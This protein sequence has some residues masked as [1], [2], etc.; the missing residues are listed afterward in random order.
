MKRDMI[1][2]LDSAWAI[3]VADVL[4]KLD[5]QTTG[6]SESE[7][8]RRLQTFGFNILP[9][10]RRFKLARILL[11][12]FKSP[13]III[14]ILAGTV[15]AI[16]AEWKDSIA[17]FAA[18][19]LNAALGFYQES[20]AE[21]ALS[22]LETYVK[23]QAIVVR[24][25]RQ[26]Q[27][28]AKDIVPG[29]IV[30]ISHGNRI[31]ADGRVIFVNDFE[32]DES[33]LTGE[34][35]SIEKTTDTVV[36]TAVLADRTNMVYMGT[37]VV[38]GF[39]DMLVTATGKSTELGII[40]TAVKF[41]GKDSTPLEKALTR[42]TY[43]IGIIVFALSLGLFLFGLSKGSTPY[44]MF[45]L[46][47]AVGVSAVPEGLP[48]ALTVILASGVQRLAR[49]KGV[50]RK[51]LAAET[52]GGT[53]VVMTDKTGTLT[54]AKMKL[55]RVVPYGSTDSESV[56]RLVVLHSDAIIEN[57]E[58]P[59]VMWRIVGRPIETAII[60]AGA[61][62]NI[63]Q[64]VVRMGTNLIERLPFT[65]T[66]KYSASFFAQHDTGT[67][68]FF[69]APEVILSFSNLNSDE[70]AKIM[71]MVDA[72]A[73]S[74]DRVLALSV[75][76]NASV[77]VNLNDLHDS[78]SAAFMGLIMFRDPVRST[79]RESIGRITRAGVRMMIVTGDHPG[80]ARTVGEELG[81][82]IAAHQVITGA[83]LDAMSDDDIKKRLPGLLVIARVSPEQKLR[84]AR[85][86]QQMGEVVAMTGD[87]VNDA[88]ALR[89]ADIGIAV[90]SGS[91]VAK[92][93][94][95]LVILDN[96]FE[97]IVAAIEEGR[98]ILQNIR[99][100]IAYLMSSV[101]DELV[102]ISG[103]LLL[104]VALPLS[105]LQILWVNLMIGALPAVALAF[106]SHKSDIG[107]KPLRINKN[108]F[109]SQLLLLIVVGTVTSFMLLGMYVGL[110]RYGF[111]P[112][113][114][115][116]FIFGSFSAY[117]LFLIFSVRSLQAPLFSYP[118]LSNQYL[119]GAV[120][121]GFIA[122]AAAIYFPPLQSLLGTTALSFP[123]IIGIIMFGVINIVFV[124]IAKWI[125]RKKQK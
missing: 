102:L 59:A 56:L 46:S 21:S 94:A 66:N 116:T 63:L 28:D 72:A 89:E 58:D 1:P 11:D 25:G 125:F 75:I 10:E 122:T 88:P 87:G 29:D 3:S 51:L 81:W 53:T 76:E 86:L 8:S 44:E 120:V 19:L 119:V 104:G 47:V 124:E 90:G 69:G 118:L 24:D 34:S 33:M 110:L 55:S 114:V 99:K 40:A 41:S 27:I 74:G 23:D 84:I 96:N 39:A 42:F 45:M 16:L 38:Q 100:V 6:L 30:R 117:A 13:L 17:I 22:V 106:E 105:A 109:D 57:P 83:E 50:V 71:S 91:D 98:K 31:P 48:I 92:A 77:H 2:N 67:A 65:S 68:V 49:K 9:K 32:V 78:H 115:R 97:I 61:A 112:I 54:E 15:T 4:Q 93:S 14:L 113:V 18:V 101:F 43:R 85:L 7:A 26:R 107:N 95:D 37:S 108:L 62:H 60:H 64:S 35:L 103:A 111:D 123:W 52:L 80:T 12:Q 20:K 5:S 70:S 36:H 79:V 73:E 82:S 121:I